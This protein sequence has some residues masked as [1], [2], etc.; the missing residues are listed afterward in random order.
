MRIRIELVGFLGNTGLPNG[1]RGGELEVADGMKLEE[2]MTLLQVFDRIPL[3]P[4]VNGRRANLSVVL[5]DND[6]V[7]FVPLVGGG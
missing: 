3:F 2:L 4:T 6:I 1:F 7:R 5:R